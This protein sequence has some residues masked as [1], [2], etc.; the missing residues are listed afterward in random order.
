MKLLTMALKAVA[1]FLGILVVI[2]GG[3]AI[4][5]CLFLSNG[6]VAYLIDP[7]ALFEFLWVTRA[8]LKVTIFFV[9]ITTF[10]MVAENGGLSKKWI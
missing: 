10:V 3:A 2:T 8:G 7:Q 5:G 6:Q 9:T 4:I 1:L